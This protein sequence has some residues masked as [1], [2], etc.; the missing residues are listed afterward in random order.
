[1]NYVLFL[2]EMKEMQA[3]SFMYLFA[4]YTVSPFQFRELPSKHSCQY[5]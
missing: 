2:K 1:M 5:N 4:T 3:K